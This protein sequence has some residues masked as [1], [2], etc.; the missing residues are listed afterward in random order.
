MCSR[1]KKIDHPAGLCACSTCI[2]RRVSSGLWLCSVGENFHTTCYEFAN[3][4][5]K[6]DLSHCVVNL[7]C[8]NT[9][10]TKTNCINF[11]QENDFAI[12]FNRFCQTCEK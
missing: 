2:P 7:Q 5:V 4:Y 6:E 11:C 12:S 9:S 10:Y 1:I 3:G 8:E